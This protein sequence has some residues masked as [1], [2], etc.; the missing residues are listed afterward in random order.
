[1]STAKLTDFG[2]ARGAR[3]PREHELIGTARYIAPERIEGRAPTER[4]D[5]Y[6]L[7]LVA[8]ELIAGR[9]PNAE[10]DTEDLLR[11]RLDGRPPSLR[12]ARVGINDEIDSVVAKAL[13]RDPHGR[14]ASAGAFARDLLAASERDDATGVPAVKRP[15]RGGARREFH[16]D[17]T[18]ALLAIVAVLIATL[19]I[20]ASFQGRALDARPTTGPSASAAAAVTPNVVGQ[21]VEDAGRILCAAGFRCPIPWQADPLA[22][23]QPCSVA[24]QEPQAGT[25]IRPGATAQLFLVSGKDCG[26]KD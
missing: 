11:L 2:I 19:A 22:R 18:L 15:L 13:A 23:G 4:S 17:T 7:G 8:Y 1:M 26:G 3:G 9:P 21:N 6:S 10:M 14:Y 5:I 16:I 25:A 20:F 24:R 12:S